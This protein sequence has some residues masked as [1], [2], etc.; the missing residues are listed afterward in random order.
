V[1]V[2]KDSRLSKVSNV[3]TARERA[4]L[5]L[6]SWKAG[7]DEDP[8]WRWRMP[9]SQVHAF[10]RLIA[11]MNGVNV[12]LKPLLV[13]L[14]LELEKLKLREGWLMTLNLWNHQALAV[15][16]YIEYGTK[17][18]DG[19]V[20]LLQDTLRHAPLL[21]AVY[22]NEEFQELVAKER[23]EREP[24]LLD[25]VVD[26][27][28]EIL[29]EGVLEQ[30]QYLR[31]VDLAVAEVAEEFE[32]EDPAL[33]GVRALIDRAEEELTEL[34]KCAE[35]YVG[36]LPLEEPDEELVEQLRRLVLGEYA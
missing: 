33:P 30:A 36:P 25:G 31:A 4:L 27:H 1:A 18:R 5:V 17:K 28:K 3:L 16:D 6:R 24:T 15:E 9:E 14:N 35:A 8:A 29:R 2:S 23:A 34:V 20:L 19:H 32:G 21:P 12:H 22:V 13:V 11:L 7:E 10:N 26:K